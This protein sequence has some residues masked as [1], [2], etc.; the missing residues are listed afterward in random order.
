[1]RIKPT[2]F[3]GSY[4]NILSLTSSTFHTFAHIFSSSSC[5]IYLSFA[6][7]HLAP[8]SFHSSASRH[9]LVLAAGFL[10]RVSAMLTNL[11]Q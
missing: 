1:M 10:C 8:A 3:F 2:F 6:P 4:H 9:C 5:L 7:A 11:T